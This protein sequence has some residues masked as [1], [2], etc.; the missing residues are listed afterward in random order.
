MEPGTVRVDGNAPIDF[1]LFNLQLIL[2]TW[3]IY[4]GNFLIIPPTASNFF[5]SVNNIAHNGVLV[6]SLQVCTV[7][8]FRVAEN[9]GHK[10][11]LFVATALVISHQ[12]WEVDGHQPWFAVSHQYVGQKYSSRHSRGKP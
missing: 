3:C 6:L 2:R 7:F 1:A 11:L 12:H 10:Q 9:K 8:K 4:F 5:N